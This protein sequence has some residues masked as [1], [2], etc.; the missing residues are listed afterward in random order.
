MSY[1]GPIEPTTRVGVETP[2]EE[3][4]CGWVGPRSDRPRIAVLGPFSEVPTGFIKMTNT[5]RWTTNSRWRTLLEEGC[6]GWVVLVGPRNG[7]FGPIS[8]PPIGLTKKTWDMM[9]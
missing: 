5:R 9:V 8:E 1:K 2:F 3:G 7:F 6:Y 4:C